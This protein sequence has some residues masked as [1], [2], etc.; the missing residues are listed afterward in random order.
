M[1]LGMSASTFTLVHVALSVVGIFAG[2][3]VLFGM[4]SSKRLE[5]WTALFLATTV[6]TS[7]TGFFFPGD[8]I[9]PSHIVG[10]ISL[11]VLAIAIFALYSRDL[12]GRWRSI[13]VVGA[14]LA[15]YLNVFVGV[16]QSFLK[17]PMLN[18]LAPTQSEPPFVIAQFAVLAIFVVLG[19]MAVRWFR[20][21]ASAPA[22]SA[23]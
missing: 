13:Y 12:A 2:L 7:L 3:V 14:V 18:A 10:L 4:F 21:R 15:L 22:F 5:G 8:Q 11:A 17:V 1:I 19:L 6:L 23:V 16:V 9:L 20:P